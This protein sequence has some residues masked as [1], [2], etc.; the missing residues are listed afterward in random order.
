MPPTATFTATTGAHHGHSPPQPTTV[1]GATHHRAHHR[2]RCHQ[3]PLPSV[4]AHRCCHLPP[5]PPLPSRH[6]HPSTPPPPTATRCR[7]HHHPSPLVVVAT[8][9]ADFITSSF[10]AY[11]TIHCNN[12]FHCHMITKQDLKW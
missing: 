6:L 2:L 9:T 10:L 3:P 5:P 7:R 12:L 11:Q 4:P 1:V 8:T